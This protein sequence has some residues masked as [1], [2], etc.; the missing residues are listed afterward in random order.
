M[1][2]ELGICIIVIMLAGMLWVI[3]HEK[4]S[5]NRGLAPSGKKWKHFATDSQGGRGYSTNDYSDGY[6]WIT[7]WWDKS[8]KHEDVDWHDPCS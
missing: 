6:I 2:Y 3:F 4:K 7:W 1:T 5:W 8:Y